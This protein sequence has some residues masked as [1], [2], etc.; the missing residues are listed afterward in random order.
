MFSFF[1]TFLTYGFGLCAI[2][3]GFVT[4]TSRIDAIPSR[5]VIGCSEAVSKGELEDLEKE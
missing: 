5:Q 2:D 1:C 3:A 4:L